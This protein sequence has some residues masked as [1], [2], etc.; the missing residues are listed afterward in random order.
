MSLIERTSYRIVV[1]HLQLEMDL[2]SW[3]SNFAWPRRPRF[4]GSQYSGDHFKKTATRS[5][6]STDILCDNH[7]IAFGRVLHL[8]KIV[9]APSS[10]TD[11]RSARG[12]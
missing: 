6:I 1:P 8:V 11:G 3:N 5:F 12:S 4:S 10:A 9:H 2:L 7:F